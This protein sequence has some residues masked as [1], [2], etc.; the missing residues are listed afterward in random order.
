MCQHPAGSFQFLSLSFCALRLLHSMPALEVSQ[1]PSRL[2]AFGLPETAQPDARAR[3]EEASRKLG[4]TVNAAQPN[5]IFAFTDDHFENFYPNNMPSIAVGVAEEHSGPAAQLLEALRVKEK[6]GFPG[7]PVVAEKLI[8]SLVHD[9]FDVSRTG[10]AEFDQ[11]VVIPWGLMK[12]DLPNVSLIPIFINVFM[13][14]L[15]PYHRAYALG[16]VV[17]R[18]IKA[19]PANC[20]PPSW[21]LNQPHDPF[22]GRMKEFQTF[23]KPVLEKYPNLFVEPDRYEMEMAKKNQYPLNLK[24]PL[25]NSDWDRLFPKH[26]CDGDIEWIKGLTYAGVEY[27]AAHGGHEALNYVAVLGAMDGAKSRLVLYEPVMEWIC[28]MAYI[29]FGVE[30]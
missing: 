9:G 3:T 10:T 8:T 11:N 21:N 25:I 7:N 17:R 26:Y 23:G 18:A 22:L 6:C 28:G 30:P 12:P 5:V 19:V 13:P 20:R 29:D 2:G 14:P 1:Y 24:H 4:R 15:I 27:N 16:Q